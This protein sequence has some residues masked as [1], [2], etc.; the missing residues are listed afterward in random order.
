MRPLLR[1]ALF[2]L[3]T[4]AL[5]AIA[6]NL[7]VMLS[8]QAANGAPILVN[9]QGMA[10]TVDAGPVIGSSI[11]GALLAAVGALVIL[12]VLPN[13]GV[14]VFAIAGAAITLASLFATTAATTPA[15][16]A[17]LAVMHVVTGTVVVVGN[18]VIHSKAKERAAVSTR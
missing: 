17:S 7:V 15:G 4:T 12:R 3:W 2:A 13:R 18:A 14:L 10:L 11:F 8:G 1:P 9:M 16:V 6:A 5:I